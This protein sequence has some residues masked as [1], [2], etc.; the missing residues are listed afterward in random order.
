MVLNLTDFQ[1]SITK[2]EALSLRLKSATGIYQNITT[3]S[4][5]CN[6]RNCNTNFSKIFIQGIILAAVSQPNNSPP[7]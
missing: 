4:I 2:M 7:S 5:L 3:N 1:F 6:Y